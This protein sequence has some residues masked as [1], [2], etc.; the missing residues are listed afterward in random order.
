M[1]LQYNINKVLTS[2]EEPVEVTKEDFIG[3]LFM[4]RDKLHLFHLKSR[5]YAEH[6]ALNEAYSGLLD[7]I[8]SITEASQCEVL[9]DIEIPCCCVKGEVAID[10]VTEC[11]SYI[12]MNRYVMG[13]SEFQNI[14]DEIMILLKTLKYKLNFLR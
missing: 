3:Y 4:I 10:S 1:K 11:M 13:R 14:I 12:E 5:S 6:I 2:I 9:L 7:Y 8:D